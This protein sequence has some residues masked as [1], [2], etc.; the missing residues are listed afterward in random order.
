ME[1]LNE[2]G[3]EI[4]PEGDVTI[5]IDYPENPFADLS[6]DDRSEFFA[7]H[8]KDDDTV[9]KL[10]MTQVNSNPGVT[11]SFT[12]SSFSIMGPALVIP[13]L[14]PIQDGQYMD[15]YVPATPPEIKDAVSAETLE[16]AFTCLA[17]GGTI[18]LTDNVSMDSVTID[19]MTS[20][21]KSYNGNYTITKLGESD[22]MFTLSESS[23]TLENV[24]I[25]ASDNTLGRTVRADNNSTL[26]LNEGA[27]LENNT[28][29]GAVYL[30]SSS[31][32]I[33]GG[34]I[35]NN[36]AEQGG[37]IFLEN[38]SILD[39]TEGI[40]TDNSAQDGGAI[41]VDDAI[42]ITMKECSFEHNIAQQDGGAI[43]VNS[44]GTLEFDMSQCTF[45]NNT[46]ALYGG[47]VKFVA[48][49]P[50]L[51]ADNCIFT[52]NTVTDVGSRGGALWIG[53]TGNDVPTDG[54]A[55]E[56]GFDSCIFIENKSTGYG[57]GKSSNIGIADGCGG[58]AVWCESGYSDDITDSLSFKDCQFDANTVAFGYSG[59]VNAE[60]IEN[61]SFIGCTMTGNTAPGWGGAV[62]VVND[63]TN[64]SNILID[65]GTFTEN[66]TRTN[67][68]VFNICCFASNITIR[69][70]ALF[71]HNVA[72]QN[73]GAIYIGRSAT[74]YP[75]RARECDVKVYMESCRILNNEGNGDL[76]VDKLVNGSS[77]DTARMQECERHY[78]A[79]AVYVGER[80]TLYM[81]DALITD[82]CIEDVSGNAIGNGITL[83]PNASAYFYP[84]HGAAVYGNG[85]DKGMDILAVP[86]DEYVHQ[87]GLPRLY[88]CDTTP[89]GQQYNW[90][91]LS[92]EVART[93]E[94]NWDNA[95]SGINTVSAFD[96]GYQGESTLEPIGFKAHVNGIMTMSVEET[97]KVIISGNVSR[98][99]DGADV[100]YGSGGL[101]VNGGII[102]GGFSITVEKQV[103]F[104][105]GFTE[106]QKNEL[107][108]KEFKFRLTLSGEPRHDQNGHVYYPTFTP[109]EGVKYTVTGPGGYTDTLDFSYGSNQRSIFTEFNLKA[110]QTFSIELDSE[111]LGFTT[112]V[113][114][115]N[116]DNYI[117]ADQLFEVD[118]IE[119][120]TGGATSDITSEVQSNNC[121]YKCTNTF[122]NSLVRVGKRSDTSEDVDT[123]FTFQLKKV[124]KYENDEIVA[125][126]D[127]ANIPY[128]VY[129]MNS[130]A[131]VLDQEMTGAD[132]TFTLKI[133]QYAELTLSL[134]DLYTVSEINLPSNWSLKSMSNKLGD[135]R[136]KVLENNLMLINLSLP[137]GSYS[138]VGP[139]ALL[140]SD[141]T[142]LFTDEYREKDNTHGELLERFTGWDTEEY[143]SCYQVPWYK[144]HSYIKSVVFE[145]NIT[146]ISTAYWF[147]NCTNL[148]TF[149][150]SNMDT[151]NVTNM[152]N[153]FNG[154]YALTEPNISDW[155]TQNVTDMSEMFYECTTLESLDLGKWDTQ[156]VTNLYEMFMS[157]VHLTTLDLSSWDT[158]RVSQ[159]TNMFSSCSSLT[160]IYATDWTDNPEI[161]NAYWVFHGC[162]RLLNSYKCFVGKMCRPKREGGYFIDPPSEDVEEDGPYAL[163]FSDGTLVFTN[164]YRI[165]DPSYGDLIDYFTGWDTETYKQAADPYNE[166]PAPWNY[167]YYPAIRSVIFEDTVSE[168]YPTSTAYWF[169]GCTRL[170]SFNGTNLNTQNVTDMSG[171]FYH[172]Y[173]LETLDLSDWNTQNVTNMSDMFNDCSKLTTLDLSTWST[174][175]ITGMHSMFR[176]C[177]AL[178]TICATDWTGN[179]EIN[180]ASDVFYNCTKLPNYSSSKI[181]GSMCKPTTMGGYFTEP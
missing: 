154:C 16:E 144:Y 86:H 77:G 92:G 106:S 107:L 112:S 153:M 138:G 100:V 166:G 171:M 9:E 142:L 8:I 41:Y 105:G 76:T 71:E 62:H 110:N 44:T 156:S 91:N 83:C 111:Q 120:D 101:M 65:G 32:N 173:S 159:I 75:E 13:T 162:D 18:W 176:G 33:N 69:D 114:D 27:I 19:N 102:S 104:I 80:C 63:S 123:D 147:Y 90:T 139:Y 55:L 157:C 25:D 181:S 15:I 45:T 82:N 2:A 126:E 11:F 160:T 79:G 89:D 164:T 36:H 84:E 98:N 177:K 3:E 103:E 52:T 20:T 117:T 14:N 118:I 121:T 58:G 38:G 125:T 70:N 54:T 128:T 48:N 49:E 178:T 87:E 132:G 17:D 26:I 130:G 72:D 6:T 66:H 81:Q 119:I 68:G 170:T 127:A 1:F 93:G 37:A 133:G 60:Y 34:T 135:G 122:R 161:N 57:A 29:Y 140:F 24:N 43:C 12:V 141:G 10:D 131:K 74:R 46:A 180:S 42:T 129:N 179:P 7:I 124:T 4:E 99:S 56:A 94:Y 148:V 136:L 22:N 134:D 47:A 113:F 97:P 88:I 21:L 61:L 137:S 39:A 85:T 174:K 30:Y 145:G 163:L 169:Y 172:C 35:K 28:T 5:T 51:I 73:A 167:G 109:I 116:A 23:L 146:A 143:T 165:N 78:H 168:V 50:K 67:G 149:D 175:N 152:S 53:L 59:A 64:P 108:D 40:F 96:D 31:I 150:G 158:S 151:R 155:N 95:L 115:Q